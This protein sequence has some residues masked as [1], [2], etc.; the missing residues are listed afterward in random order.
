MELIDEFYERASQLAI[1]STVTS[2][3]ASDRAYKAQMLARRI[4]S[5][6]LQKPWK[7]TAEMAGLTVEVALI[8]R[9][10]K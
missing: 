7:D 5:V 6:V 8:L 1:K 4:V 3:N 10:E 9:G 2:V